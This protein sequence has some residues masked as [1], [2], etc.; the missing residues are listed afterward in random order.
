MAKA[1][2]LHASGGPEN[3]R[4]DVREQRSFRATRR[5]QRFVT[6][7]PRQFP[8]MAQADARVCAR[9]EWVWDFL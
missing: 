4:A 1:V 9:K 3:G 7:R 5:Q 6:L 2:E 8:R